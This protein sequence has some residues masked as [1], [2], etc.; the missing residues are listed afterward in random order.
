MS[1]APQERPTGA[2]D[3]IWDLSVFY[4]DFDDP[5]LEA[6][7]ERLDELAAAFQANWRGKVA[8]MTASDF[9][10]AY[11]QMEIIYD[12][13]GRLGAFAFLNFSTDTAQAEYQAAVARVEELESQLSQRM[14]FFALEWNALDDERAN[15]ILDD[16]ALAEHR[17]TLEA[18]RRY[19]PHNLTEAEEQ[20]SIEKS[21]TG[22]SAWT[23]FF[24]QLT[25]AFRFDWL[26][27]QVNM[28]FVLNKLRDADRDTREMAWRKLSDK[29]QEKQMELTFIF[30]TLALDKANSDRRRGYASWVSS[31]NLSNK[32]SDEV[33]EALVQT[34]TSNYDL[35]ARHYHLKRALLGYEEL[36]DY[37][38]YAPLNLKESEAFYNWETARAIVLAAFD[39][40][41]PDM[42]AVAKRFFD[43]GWIHAPV[44]P[45][46][47]GG[48][49][50]APTVASANP[51]VFLNYLGD[52]RDV[53]TLAHELG[54]GIHMYLSGQEKGL[55]ALYTPLTTAEMAS[56]FAEM[57]VFQDLM[58]AESD[59]EIKLSMLLEKIEDTF[60][61]VFRQIS[62]NRFEDKMH[63]ARR[64]EGELTAE[65]F[66]TMWLETQR[67]MFGD[68]LTITDEYGSWWSYVPHFLHT[69]GYVYAYS[70]G[71]LLVL[72]L[73]KMYQEAGA[74]FVPRYLELLA[75]GD[76][77]YP[78][79]LL[80]K[81]GV[82]INAPR[83]WQKGIDVIAEWIEQAQNLA[84]QL[85]PDKFA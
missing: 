83:F 51:F 20:I 42:Q 11:Q 76:S 18:E 67:D 74:D 58:A 19:R 28:T 54:H 9:V 57:L 4:T 41:S 50:A 25:S 1:A 46:K 3:V 80:A 44:L 8:R 65:R 48:A 5:R 35:V 31:R 17:Y 21:V 37:D 22:S 81:V 23:R 38:R 40:F 24:T 72:A 14:V 36:Y 27:E 47:R 26:G 56:T 10:Q 39:N 62:M 69:P 78:D 66:N 68:S 12:L 34:V 84:R 33:V 45:N 63:N 15:T 79:R 30:N 59:P 77:D 13:R 70:F 32:A 75:A 6:D 82:D 85:Y 7:I 73:Y 61:T 55:F 49:F 64:E 53:T 43:C 29:L 52:A 2:E 16:P 71:E 60:A